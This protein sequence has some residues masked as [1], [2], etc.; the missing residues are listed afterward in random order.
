MEKTGLFD[1]PAFTTTSKNSSNDIPTPASTHTTLPSIPRPPFVDHK[2]ASDH[3]SDSGDVWLV[4]T[5]QHQPQTPH[6]PRAQ[7]ERPKPPIHKWE[8]ILPQAVQPQMQP[9]PLQQTQSASSSQQPADRNLEFMKKTSETHIIPTSTYSGV[10]PCQPD[11]VQT[12]NCSKIPT[13]PQAQQPAAQIMPGPVKSSSLDDPAPESY[14][15]LSSFFSTSDALTK[16]HPLA[17]VPLYF[18]GANSPMSSGSG[19]EVSTV[20]QYQ[21]QRQWPPIQQQLVSPPIQFQFQEQIQSSAHQLQSSDSAHQQQAQTV[22]SLQQPAPTFGNTIMT[23][24]SSTCNAVSMIPGVPLSNNFV[25]NSGHCAM[26]TP[27]QPPEIPQLQIN[28][29]FQPVAAFPSNTFP[30]WPLPAVA[31]A[32]TDCTSGFVVASLKSKRDPE[33]SSLDEDD[34]VSNSRSLG[35]GLDR[36]TI[37]RQRNTESA[38]R[39]RQRKMLQLKELEEE[40]DVLKEENGVLKQKDTE[41][42]TRQ[43]VLEAEIRQWREKDERS[44]HHIER[45]EK[46]LREAQDFISLLLASNNSDGRGH[47]TPS[48]NGQV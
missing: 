31:P 43:T 26:L 42:A 29:I 39:C 13:P 19:S 20:T 41:W 9:L 36:A 24:S 28:N 5:Q 40:N 18:D 6:I 35:D 47:H 33:Y 11:I 7:K 10:F 32:A 30:P 25:P 4:V 8:V 37:R 46:Q 48:A 45:L 44:S 14:Y 3:T 2:G 34:D 38:R 15:V 22:A 16:S 23:V 1:N 27:Q 21:Q 17:S 12:S